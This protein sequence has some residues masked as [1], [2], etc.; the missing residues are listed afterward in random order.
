MALFLVFVWAFSGWLVTQNLA[1]QLDVANELKLASKDSN[2]VV[3]AYGRTNT[4]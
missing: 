1:D 3:Y 4:R 2:V